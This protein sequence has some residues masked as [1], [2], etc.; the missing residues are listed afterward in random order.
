MSNAIFPNT[1]K[2]LSWDV[3]ISDE[4]DTIVYPAPNAY[5]TRLAKLQDPLLRFKLSY[6][7]LRDNRGGIDELNTIRAFFRARQGG[8]DSFLLYLPDLTQNPLDG[9]VTDQALTVDGNKYAPFVHT[10]GGNKET[11]Y[12]IKTLT[13]VKDNGVTVAGGNY[14]TLGPSPTTV[15]GGTSYAGKVL[16]FAVAYTPTLPVTSTFSY[17]YRVRFAKDAADYNAFMFQLYEM[18]ELELVTART[19]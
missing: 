13:N 16:K 15:Y 17:Y 3:E 1:L 12:E 10:K 19:L 6:E 8:F 7:V 5:D 14:T 2:G 4:F 9:S 18:K 11:I